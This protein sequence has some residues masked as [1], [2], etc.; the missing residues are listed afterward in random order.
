MWIEP[1]LAG[2]CSEPGSCIPTALGAAIVTGSK[3]CGEAA[4]SKSSPRSKARRH[5]NSWFAFKPW[6]RA[7]CATLAP[8]SIVNCTI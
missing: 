2:A 6:A 3:A 5:L 7:T 4:E 1:Y 8:G